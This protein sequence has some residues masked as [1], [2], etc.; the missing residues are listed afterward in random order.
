MKERDLYFDNLKFILILLVVTGHFIEPFNTERTVGTL[1]QWI[2]SFHMPLFIF[3]AG[4]FSK[5]IRYPK[6]YVQLVSSLVVPYFLF[7]TLYTLFDYYTQGLDKLDFTYFYPYWI[8]WFMFSMMLWKMLLPYLLI[9]KH[10][11]WITISMSVMLGYSLDVDYYA[12][13]SRTLYFL[14][15][16]MLG[17]FFKREWLDLLKTRRVQLMSFLVLAAGAVLLYGLMPILPTGWFYG[18]MPYLALDLEMWYAGIYR[19]LTYGFTV[20][21]GLCVLSLIP[22]SRQP[23]T[24]LGVNTMY[25]FLLHGFLVK[26]MLYAGYF[27]TFNST[28]GKI[29]LIGIAVAV[30]CILSSSWIKRGFGWLVE[31]NYGF[32]FKERIRR[33]SKEVRK[34]EEF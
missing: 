10:P 12:S 8:L 16:F 23:F 15:F 13:I 31:P 4:Y 18:A 25:V 26:G 27:E 14:P 19:V 17:F 33:R 29:L 28:G 6:Y 34:K 3:T 21:M 7:E 5:N 9:L 11:L 30:T 32:L 1:Y 2:Y 20:L 24:D 22:S